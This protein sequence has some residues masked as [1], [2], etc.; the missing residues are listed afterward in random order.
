MTVW[1]VESPDLSSSVSRD[2]E[3]VSE[4]SSRGRGPEAGGAGVSQPRCAD[5][6]NWVFSTKMAESDFCLCLF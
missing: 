5:L 1:S 4:D 6:I 2:A 3:D